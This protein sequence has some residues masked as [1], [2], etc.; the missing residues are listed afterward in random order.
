[1]DI[2]RKFCAAV[3]HVLVVGVLVVLSNAAGA[4]QAYPNKAIRLIVPYAAGGATFVLAQ[5]LGQKLTESMGQPVVMDVRP[6]VNGIIGSEAMTKSAPDGY[7]L[8]LVASSHVVTGALVKNLP[9]DSIK[10]FAPVATITFSE[11]V[12]AIYPKFPAKNVKELIDLCKSKPGAF[13]F[14]TAGEGSQGHLANALFNIKTGINVQHIAY[15]GSGPALND[16]VSG[17][18]QMTFQPPSIVGPF[19]KGGKLRA[20]AITGKHRLPSLPEVPTFA[21]QGVPDLDVTSWY[22]LLAPVGIPSPIVAKLSATINKILTLPDM[23]EKLDGIGM[24]PYISTT[25]QFGALMKADLAKF[26]KIAKDANIHPMD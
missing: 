21:E 19:I 15:K 2:M 18:V 10:D 22:A 1:M 16:V 12:F 7:T 4:Q 8:L 23:K 6:G 13:N 24:E 20:L 14:S 9:Y 26:A 11:Y 3:T 17:Q 5:L 25:E